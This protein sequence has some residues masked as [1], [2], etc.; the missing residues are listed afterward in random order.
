MNGKYSVS[1]DGKSQEIPITITNLTSRDI[2][3]TIDGDTKIPSSSDASF[4]V[5]P[6]NHIILSVGVSGTYRL[7]GLSSSMPLVSDAYIQAGSFHDFGTVEEIM[8][9][10]GEVAW[11]ILKV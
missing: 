4:D 8:S 1:Q 9:Q 2:T 11:G 5:Y 10:T 7:M 6:D 3:I